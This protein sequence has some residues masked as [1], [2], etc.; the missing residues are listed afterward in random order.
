MVPRLGGYH[1]QFSDSSG[2]PKYISVSRFILLHASKQCTNI[3]DKALSTMA[4]LT[5]N[6]LLKGWAFELNQLEFISGVFQ[7]REA[8]TTAHTY[9]G[10]Q[11]DLDFISRVKLH[12]LFLTQ[13]RTSMMTHP[14]PYGV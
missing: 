2:A 12:T 3:L 1:S 6:P 10:R 9:I 11:K 7:E 13:T 14:Q 8:S 5:G 4:Q